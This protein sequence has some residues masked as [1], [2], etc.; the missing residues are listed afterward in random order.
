MPVTKANML[1]SKWWHHYSVIATIGA[2]FIVSQYGE[3]IYA[4]NKMATF[5]NKSKLFGG[6]EYPPGQK[7]W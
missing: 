7:P 5:R 2:V 3:K 6:K 1:S 4:D